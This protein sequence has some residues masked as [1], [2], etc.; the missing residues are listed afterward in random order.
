MSSAADLQTAISE[1]LGKPHVTALVGDG[2]ATVFPFVHN[3]ATNVL[4]LTVKAGAAVLVEGVD[5]SVTAPDINSVV[6]TALAGPPAPEAWQVTAGILR[7]PVPVVNRR[8]KSL[9]NDVAAAVASHGL[10]INVLPPLPTRA[11]QGA[12]FVFFEAATVR[13][14]VLEKPSISSRYGCDCW[15][16][17]DDVATA[18]HWQNFPMLSHPLQLAP[19]PTEIFAEAIQERAYDVLF[20]ATYGISRTLPTT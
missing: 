3:L 4:T 12:P 1:F 2:S 14:R 10:C 15:D 8:S 18:L 19:K 5:F 9:A 13:V 6:I 20:I 16:I 11:N 7:A 17:I